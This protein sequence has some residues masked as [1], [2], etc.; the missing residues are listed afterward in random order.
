VRKD[1]LT[2][3]Q[4]LH[5]PGSIVERKYAQSRCLRGAMGASPHASTAMDLATLI[6]KYLEIAGGF[7]RPVHLSQLGLSK[8]ETEKV[9]SALDEDYQI[10]RYMLL[11]R[12]LDVSLAVFPPDE[13][14]YLVNGYECSHVSFQEGV[15]KLL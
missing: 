14:V 2:T 1:A 6:K 5:R 9:I 4:E 3:L 10:S 15:Q 13:R 8:A 7:G 12:E 11:S